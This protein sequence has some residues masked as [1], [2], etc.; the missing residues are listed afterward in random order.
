MRFILVN[1]VENANF[2]FVIQ[3]SSPLLQLF[4][5]KIYGMFIVFIV[6]SSIIHC[7]KVREITGYKIF[8]VPFAFAQ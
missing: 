8:A 3:S 2:M 6:I 7:F 5:D 4:F 1:I